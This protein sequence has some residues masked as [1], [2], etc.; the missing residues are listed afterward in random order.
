M[1]VDI[2]CGFEWCFATSSLQVLY[3]HGMFRQEIVNASRYH[4]NL[5]L[6]TILNRFELLVCLASV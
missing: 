2:C 6:N 3:L 4:P 1:S 5:F